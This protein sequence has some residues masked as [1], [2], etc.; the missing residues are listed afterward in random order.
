MPER[1]TTHR[2]LLR[3]TAAGCSALLSLVLACSCG[4]G[5]GQGGPRTHG[6]ASP[7]G[8][9]S[10][11]P[12]NDAAGKARPKPVPGD[13]TPSA[14]PP[15]QQPPAPPDS[16]V[17]YHTAGGGRTVALTFDDGP[18]PATGQILDLL[19]KYHVKATFCQVGEEIV[20]YPDI[21]RRILA[22]GHRLCD[23]TLT[24]PQPMFTLSSAQQAQEVLDAKATII[25]A[26]GP[27]TRVT[28]FRAPGGD[29]TT[30]NVKTAVEHGMRPLGWTVD[31][32]D[33]SDP[34]VDSIVTTVKQ[35]LQPG[36]IV[37]FHDGGGDRSQTVTAVSR[38]LPW[39]IRQGYGFDFP[40]N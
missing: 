22:E 40:E 37:L 15:A 27:G 12:G 26:G 2:P 23:H 14:P 24:H 16:S 19:A 35:E 10:A 38:L 1:G 9:R 21:D 13:N 5:D 11:G 3:R 25:E 32:V 31:P 18:G 4:L 30:A 6:Q 29:F 36:G 17:T 33:W 34:G 28:W 8:A 39:L 7:S 20:N